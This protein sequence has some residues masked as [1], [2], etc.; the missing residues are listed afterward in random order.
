MGT[1]A[2]DIWD[3]VR[4]VGEKTCIIDRHPVMYAQARCTVVC[5]DSVESLNAAVE[6]TPV[7]KNANLYWSCLISTKCAKYEKLGY[8]LLDCVVGGKF[9]SGNSLHRAFSDTDKSRLA[10]IYAKCL[11]PVACPVSFGDLSWAKIVR[12]SFSLLLSS[13]NVLVDDGSSLEIK[14]S[15]LVTMEV[16]NKFAALE[17]SLTSLMEQ[18]GKL[19]KRLDAF[20]P[21]VPQPSPGY[22]F[23]GVQVFTSGLDSGHLGAGVAVIMNVFLARHMYK[24]SEV[25]GQ[26]LSIKLLFKSKLSVLILGLYGASLAVWLSQAGEINSLIAKAVN[27]SSFIILGGDFNEDSSHKCA[28]FRKCLDLGLA[29]SLVRSPA[30]KLP[31]WANSR[32]ARK[33]IDY[34][35]VSSNLVNVIVY[36]SVLDISEHFEIDHQAVSVSLSL[37]GLLDMQLNSLHKQVNR[38]CWKFNFKGAMA[39]NAAMFSDDFIAS[40]QF[41]DLDAMWDIVYKIMILSADEVF[42]KKWFKNYDGVFT[43]NSSKFHKLKLLISKLVKASRLICRN[44][45]IHCWMSG[46]LLIIIMPLWLDLFFSPALL[47]ILFESGPVR[48]RVDEIMEGWTRKHRVVPNVSDVWHH[49]YRPLNYVFN[50]AFSDV[51]QPIEFLELFGMVSDLSINKTTGFSAYDSVGWEHLKK[52]LVKIKMCGKFI[53]FFSNIHRNQT[54]RVMTDFGL[55]DDYS[56]HNGLDQGEVFSPLLWC[57][58]YDPFLYE[59]KHQKSVCGYRLN[60]HFVFRSGHAESQA[61]FFTFFAAGAFVDNMIWVGSS[62]AATQHILNVVSEFFRINDISINNDKTV[63]IFINSRISNPSLFISGSLISIAKKG[64]SHQYL[65]IFLSTDGF[66]KPN[67]AKAHS[68]I[69]FFSNLVLKKAVSDKQFLYLVLAV[70]HPIKKLDPCGPV[71]E[72]FGHSVVFLS[73]APLSSL[74]LCGVGP[75]DI[76]GSDDFVSVCDHLSRVGANNLSVYTDGLMKNLG[77]TGCRAGAVAFFEDI[78]LGLGVHVQGLILSTLA[79]LQTIALALECVPVDHSVCL[80]L[81]SQAALDACKSEINLAHWEVGSGSGFLAGDLHSDVNWLTS[82]GVW[83][84]DLHMATGFTSRHTVDIRTYL[85]KALHYQ[86]PIAVRKCIYDKCYS[87]V[88]CLYCGKMEVSNHVFSCMIDD[89]AR[90]W[91]L[92]SYAVDLCFGF[93]AVSI[94]H[95]SKVAGI[96]IADFVHSICVAFRNDIWLVCAK[97]RAYIEK[98]GLISVDGSISI[99]ISGLTSRFSNGVVKLLGIGDLVSVNIIA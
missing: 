14:P 95:D 74:A 60:S 25:P 99:S 41:S 91:I 54:N 40:Q 71:P 70:L 87:S 11:A 23:D 77:T 93:P 59:V 37:G 50:K 56:I 3:F 46:V 63:A 53:R 26:L 18:V 57:I 5:F 15:L 28:S 30:V 21:M 27:E 39:A 13:Q 83:H 97:Y 62:Q 44:K 6:T 4:S 45:F 85:M 29:N 69:R 31:T 68:D 90:R 16:N 73:G 76:C 75:I 7:L 92:E 84:L 89:A 35:F 1:N 82:S 51:M 49:Q 33:T 67:L 81:D 96:N 98:N 36:H 79:E 22:K 80:F 38:D 65:G 9:S 12:K 24:I 17:C 64:K 94:F 61:G 47:L 86:L 20:R 58:F 42:K 48:S 8:M 43:K 88:L 10:V 2:H 32:G 55:T 52:Y 72:W 78:D 19:A 34:V 66:S